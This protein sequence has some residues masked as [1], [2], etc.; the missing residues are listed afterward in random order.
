M[1][2]HLLVFSCPLIVLAGLSPLAG[3][4]DPVVSLYPQIH[5]ILNCEPPLS[6]SRAEQV[7]INA[8][9][10]YVYVVVAKGDP[11]D[12]VSSASFGIATESSMFL[13]WSLCADS[14]SSGANWPGNGSGNRVTWDTN[15]C[16]RT[17]LNPDGVHAVAG[18]MYVYTYGANYLEIT[19]NN[20]VNPPEF[21]ITDCTGGTAPIVAGG[22]MGFGDEPGYNPCTSGVPVEPSRWGQIKALFREP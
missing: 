9:T 14:E 12:G 21:E 3:A 5:P 20:S 22:R 7:T 1:R 6:C 11:V 2:R 8:F 16:Q 17:V 4:S 13:E 10:V 15:N 19:P 18:T